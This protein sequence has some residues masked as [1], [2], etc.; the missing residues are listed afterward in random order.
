MIS[1][2]L[3]LLILAGIV[4][5][6]IVCT[7]DDDTEKKPQPNKPVVSQPHHV[8]CANSKCTMNHLD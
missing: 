1:Q 2:L 5:T 3:S 8:H 6:C 4:I 7:P